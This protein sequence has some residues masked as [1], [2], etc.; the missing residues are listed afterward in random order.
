ML[1]MVVLYADAAVGENVSYSFF[2][3]NCLFHFRVTGGVSLHAVGFFLSVFALPWVNR[4]A[5]KKYMNTGR[6]KT[7]N[8]GDWELNRVLTTET[9][10]HW[11]S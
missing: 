5:L 8:G 1:V 11:D 7:R 2:L 6:T 3:S 9:P 4:L 10:H